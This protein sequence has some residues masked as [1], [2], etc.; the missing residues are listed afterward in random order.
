MKYLHLYGYAIMIV[1]FTSAMDVAEFRFD[2]WDSWHIIKWL[3][4]AYLLAREYIKEH[5]WK[6]PTFTNTGLVLMWLLLITVG[7]H[8]LILHKLF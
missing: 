8:H 7:L 4:F 6:L 1:L 3:F 5:G 2:G